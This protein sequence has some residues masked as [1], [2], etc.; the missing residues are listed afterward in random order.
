MIKHLIFDIGNVLVG[1]EWRDFLYRDYEK[2]TAEVLAGAVFGG[3]AWPRL[4]VGD[5]TDEEEVQLFVDL[6]PAYEKE[7]RETCKHMGD[8]LRLYEATLPW[9]RE[10]KVKG[11]RL[12]ALSNWPR[13]MYEQR[14]HN[15]D[16]LEEM[17]G[18]VLSYRVHQVKPNPG[19]YQLLLETY[20]IQPE[21]AVFLDDT[22]VNVEAAERLGIHGIHFKSREQAAEELRA[23]GVE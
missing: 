18:Y 22:L 7:I 20:G 5:L 6:A 19:I 10:L 3:P 21:E 13:Q 17:D 11:Y 14:G 2:E 15:L 4:D 23:L 9:L 8:C 16:F 1:F 12:Y